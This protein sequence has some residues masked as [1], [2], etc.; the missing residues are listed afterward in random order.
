MSIP[1][2]VC[3]WLLTYP[4]GFFN[5][6]FHVDIGK[7]HL[8]LPQTEC[9]LE[10]KGVC[11]GGEKHVHLLYA[12][13]H[14]ARMVFPW[15]SSDVISELSGVCVC[16]CGGGTFKQRREHC[17]SKLSFTF[18]KTFPLRPTSLFFTLRMFGPEP[19]AWI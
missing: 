15:Q 11:G 7:G 1:S 12:L 4:S 6:L 18:R 5:V 16:V 8:S 19:S 2:K 10:G 17:G 13:G 14:V 3:L 9:F